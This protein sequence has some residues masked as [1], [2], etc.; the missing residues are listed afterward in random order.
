MYL[1]PRPPLG[2]VGP[3]VAAAAGRLPLIF[4]L[5]SRIQKEMGKRGGL[6]LRIFVSPVA[7]KS[8]WL[9]DVA[10]M[11]ALCS[12]RFDR[13]CDKDEAAVGVKKD[14]TS[15][16]PRGRQRS[17]FLA[18]GEAQHWTDDKV[19]LDRKR[20]G[21]R[22]KKREKRDNEQKDPSLMRYRG[23]INRQ[24][25]DRLIRYRCG[26]RQPCDQDVT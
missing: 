5:E 26:R 3:F 10:L 6:S 24:R 16:G 4:F 19:F 21:R 17:R 13:R 9:R 11:Q 2:A 18:R 15:G 7:S 14:D 23:L 8:S 25:P 22:K 20:D 1:F 12:Y